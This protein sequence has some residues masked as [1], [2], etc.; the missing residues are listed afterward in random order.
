[1][2]TSKPRLP[3]MKHPERKVNSKNMAISCWEKAKVAAKTRVQSDISKGIHIIQANKTRM[4][5][6]NVRASSPL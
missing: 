1:M 6:L 3:K 2:T 5:C 4:L